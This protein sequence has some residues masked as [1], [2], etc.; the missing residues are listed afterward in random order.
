LP[1]LPRKP[2]HK[3]KVESGIGYTQDNALKGLKFDSLEAQNAH[4]RDWNRR[5]AR[6]RIHG[7]IKQQVWA[8]FT[9]V[10]RPALQTL[11]EKPF[12]YFKIGTR[13]V[14]ADGHIEVRG[15]YYSVPHR[16]LG[17][18]LTVH[19]N[20]QWVK[21]LADTDIVAFHRRAQPG[22]FRTQKDHLPENKTLTQE[23]YKAR[24]LARC[25]TV[26]EA[27]HLWAQRA[28]KERNQQ[29]FRAI[30]GLLRLP[31]KYAPE[32][33]EKACEQARKIGALNYHT[34]ASLCAALSRPE[35]ANEQLE[36]LQEH[37]IIRD[38]KHYQQLI[39]N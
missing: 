20:D 14:H 32:V 33:V 13:K 34:V 15:A 24:L 18:S 10:E 36:L 17:Q 12:A 37:D 30:Q 7:T 29:A 38:L 8:V 21:V 11:P 39:E 4:L 19:F 26:G 22:R 5:W 6:T 25:A 31:D 27:T 23:Q 3:G 2:E 1:C 28:L 9:D 16:Y 35:A